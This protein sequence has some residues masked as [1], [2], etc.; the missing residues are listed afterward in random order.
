MRC[1]VVP[2]IAFHRLRRFYSLAYNLLRKKYGQE[3]TY[4]HRSAE[5]SCSEPKRHASHVQT[6]STKN[7]AMDKSTANGNTLTQTST[8]A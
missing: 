4:N 7:R 2:C 6:S 3:P 1:A 8:A 5:R